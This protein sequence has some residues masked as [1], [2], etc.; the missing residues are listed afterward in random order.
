MILFNASN[1]Y[2]I[3]WWFDSSARRKP[4]ADIELNKAS[5]LLDVSADK[6]LR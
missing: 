3:K 2:S 4:G 5:S 1:K 6:F